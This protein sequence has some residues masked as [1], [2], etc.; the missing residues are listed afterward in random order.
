MSNAETKKV[1]TSETD[2][3]DI[4][5]THDELNTQISVGIISNTPM[6]RD[7]FIAA[8]QYFID[9]VIDGEIEFLEP[10]PSDGRH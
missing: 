3:F 1:L 4:W 9:N 2:E 8:L 10:S 7:E 5:T 6:T